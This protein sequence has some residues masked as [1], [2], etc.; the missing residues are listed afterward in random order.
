MTSSTNLSIILPQEIVRCMYP[1]DF[2]DDDMIITEGE[3]GDMLYALEGK[4]HWQNTLVETPLVYSNS[5]D[6]L[7]SPESHPILRGKSWGNKGRS[8][9]GSVWRPDCLWGAGYSLQVPQNRIYTGWDISS[10]VVLQLQ[11]YVGPQVQL[12]L[13]PL[14]YN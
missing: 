4:I 3:S 1:V 13:E 14:L 5:A 12:E 8:E 9:A 10:P 6:L 2:K 7:K 11:G